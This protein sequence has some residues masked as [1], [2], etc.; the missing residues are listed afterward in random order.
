MDMSTN[1]TMRPRS[2]HTLVTR[3]AVLIRAAVARGAHT[4][5]VAMNVRENDKAI[6][7]LAEAGGEVGREGDKMEGG[8]GNEPNRGE[9]ERGG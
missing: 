8:V 5:F 7:G 1:N 3:P 4:T 6:A 9:A 2:S